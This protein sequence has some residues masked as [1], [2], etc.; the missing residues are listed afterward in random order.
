M[1]FKAA[2]SISGYDIMQKYKVI[3]VTGCGGPKSCEMSRLP[4]FL[5]N[6]ITDGGEFVSLTC[7]PADLHP[8]EDHWY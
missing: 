1:I 4:H 8:Q 5:D 3:P 6:W 2:K 7:Q